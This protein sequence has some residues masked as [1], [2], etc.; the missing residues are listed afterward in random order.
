MYAMFLAEGTSPF[1]YDCLPLP[2]QMIGKD[3]FLKKSLTAL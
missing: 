1:G 3:F 2:C